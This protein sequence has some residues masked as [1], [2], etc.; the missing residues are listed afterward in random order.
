MRVITGSAR[1]ARLLSPQGKDIRPTSEMAKEAVFS[2]LQNEIGGACVL[3]LFAGSGQMGIEA[4]SR[5]A[6]RCIFVD[7]AKQAQKMVQENLE[8]TKLAPS[9]RVVPMDFSAF[10]S[11]TAE[12]FDIAFLDP[13]YHQGL[14]GKALPLTAAVMK[15]SGVIVCETDSRQALPQEAG[16][17]VKSREYRYG[18]TKITLYRMGGEVRSQEEGSDECP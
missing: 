3:D 1:G 2:I 14:L 7:S 11:G 13:P 18:K 17:F 4:L 15:P 6:V 10:L 12:R 9:A 16:G 5:G 8:R